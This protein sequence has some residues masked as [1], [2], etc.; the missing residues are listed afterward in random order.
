MRKVVSFLLLASLVTMVGCGSKTTPAETGAQPP[1]ESPKTTGTAPAGNKLPKTMKFG[2]ASPKD[3]PMSK[4]AFKFAELAE[5]ETKGAIKVE[6]FTDGTLGGDVQMINSLKAGT[7][8]AASIA[9]APLASSSKSM[10]LFELPFLFKDEASAYKVLDGE[11]GKQVLADLK[12]LNLI[13]LSYMENGFRH[14]TTAS[15][16]IKTVADLKGLKIRTQESPIHLDTWKALGTTP[17]AI[18]FTELF[19]ALEQKVVDGQENPYTNI[20]FKNMYEVQKYLINTGH[21]Y[22][23]NPLIIGQKFWDTLTKEEQ[24]ALQKAADE[25]TKYQRE[26]SQQENKAAV[27]FLKDKGMIVHDMTPEAHKEFVDKLKPVYD[28]YRAELGA[29]LVDNL[30]NA[31]KN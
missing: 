9:S 17:T 31:A 14:L 16:D 26:L 10:N 3:H 22:N 13:G 11:I 29:D 28:K 12:N 2:T 27:Q 25:A 5:K 1:A 4:G 21:V 18:A 24:Q 7:L 6:V 30:L 8:Q 15:K 20:K 19:T 23:V